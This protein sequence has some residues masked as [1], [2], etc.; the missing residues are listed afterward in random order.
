[1][2]EFNTRERVIIEIIEGMIEHQDHTYGTAIEKLSEITP[3]SERELL[4]VWDKYCDLYCEI[5]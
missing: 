1:M 3:S 4:K 2:K 5:D